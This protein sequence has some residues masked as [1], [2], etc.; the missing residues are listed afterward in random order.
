MV[1]AT[2]LVARWGGAVGGDQAAGFR[3]TNLN[4]NPNPQL[5]A[6][7]ESMRA[8]ESGLHIHE[9]RVPDL[10]AE[11][12]RMGALHQNSSWRSTELN[13]SH[14]LCDTYPEFLCVPKETDA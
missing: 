8:T 2:E 6:N 3:E 5:Q 14:S 4:P 10:E 1:L 11:F 7:R 9:C 13:K 12:V